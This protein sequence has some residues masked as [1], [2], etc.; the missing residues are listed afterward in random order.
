MK[1][2]KNGKKMTLKK[3]TISSLEITG[4]NEVK[5]GGSTYTSW[6]NPECYCDSKRYCSCPLPCPWI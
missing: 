4:L 2:K 5:G 1:R 6:G 3:E